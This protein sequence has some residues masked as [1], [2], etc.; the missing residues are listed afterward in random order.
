MVSPREENGRRVAIVLSGGGA[1]G[2]YEAGVLS[3]LFEHIYPKLGDD[4]HFDILSGTSVGAIHAAYMAASAHM[5]TRLRTC[6]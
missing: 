6:R 2:A 1:R 5:E 3:Y 4:F